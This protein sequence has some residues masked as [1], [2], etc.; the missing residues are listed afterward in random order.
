MNEI[1]R[2][3]SDPFRYVVTRT[4]L[5]FFYYLCKGDV[6][7]A[8]TIAAQKDEGFIIT[9]N[10]VSYLDWLVLQAYFQS[11]HNL[12]PTFLAK[13]KL[14]DHWLWKRIVTESCCV[15]VSNDGD[16]ILSP[17]DFQRLKETKHIILFPEG[18]RSRNGELGLFKQGA[19]KLAQR[20]NL[21]I[22][23]MALHGFYE[24]WSPNAKLPKPSR[25]K[26]VVGSPYTIRRGEDVTLATDHLRAQIMEIL[27]V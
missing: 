7:R 8:D 5:L 21:P 20:L 18:T 25:C 26:I 19:A 13:E 15:A 27:T 12:D 24:A 17:Y 14:F 2:F 1:K 9:V 23:P 16:R 11:K 4:A 22:L 10:H 3:F 6:I